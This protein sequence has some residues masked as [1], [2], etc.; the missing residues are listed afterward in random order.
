MDTTGDGCTNFFVWLAI[1]LLVLLT[2]VFPVAAFIID[3]DRAGLPVMILGLAAFSHLIAWFFGFEDHKVFGIVWY[4]FTGIGVILVIRLILLH[5]RDT[6]AR[7]PRSGMA[8][9]LAIPVSVVIYGLALWLLPAGLSEGNR[10]IV[11]QVLRFLILLV[12]SGLVYLIY[13]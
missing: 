13:R 10:K 3:P 12:I 2:L 11:R 6:F 8:E 7:D 5:I 1:G 4:G 9:A